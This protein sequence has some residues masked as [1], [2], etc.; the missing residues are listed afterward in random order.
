VQIADRCVVAFHYTL[1]NSLGETIDSSEGHSPLTYLHGAGNIVPGLESAM[2]GRQ[3]GDRF[4]VTVAAADGYGERDEAA[5]VT[6][7]CC[8]RCHALPFRE[9]MNSPSE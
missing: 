5:S 9:L 4:D 7:R 1:T 2:S 6:R 3:A 8:S